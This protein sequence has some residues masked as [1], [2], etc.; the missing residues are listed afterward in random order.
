MILKIRFLKRYLWVFVR[1]IFV[2]NG[3]QFNPHG[4]PV[5]LPKNSDI[6]IRYLLAR[7]RP[8]E[9]P[10]AKMVRQYI[11]NGSNVIE[12]G[13]C[14]GII[15]A[16]IRKQI[17]PNAKHIIVE[18]DPSLATICSV[19]AN[20]EN[21]INE[22]EVVVA[23]VDYSGSKEITFAKG[24]NAHVGHIALEGEPGFNVPTTTLAEQV[25]KLPSKEYVLV[26]DIEGAELNLLENEKKSLSKAYLLILE[27]HPEIYPE[28][29]SDLLKL[30]ASIERLGLFEIE[31]SDSVICYGSKTAMKDLNLI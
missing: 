20:L 5:E 6:S 13:G 9:A 21:T 8:Y 19:N 10:E 2:P 1:S 4:I 11:T 24:R 7:G 23:A 3:E 27:T 22:A 31:K 17:G 28:K 26:C 16:L 29:D 15:S 25:S 14:Y 18:A 30:Q 12:L